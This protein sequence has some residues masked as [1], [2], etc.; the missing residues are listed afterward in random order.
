MSQVMQLHNNESAADFL[1]ELAGKLR[2]RQGAQPTTIVVFGVRREDD[3]MQVEF[4]AGPRTPSALEFLGIVEMGKAT[5]I[6]SS[7]G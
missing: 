5:F 6:A 7:D 1:G 4:F 3:A 2:N